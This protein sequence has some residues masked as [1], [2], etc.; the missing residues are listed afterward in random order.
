MA[1]GRHT[2]H[3]RLRLEFADARMMARYADGLVLVVRAN[4]T[5]RKTAQAVA[6]RL[7]GDG[8]RVTGIILN[9]WDQF[10]SDVY[11]Y[12]AFRSTRECPT[13]DWKPVL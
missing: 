7:E 6:R 11:G 8:T 12:L 1:R 13:P 5:D 2:S 10:R 4:D 9:R 3:S